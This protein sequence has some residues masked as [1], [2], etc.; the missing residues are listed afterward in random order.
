LI[1]DILRA[2]KSVPGFLEAARIRLIEGSPTLRARQKQHLQT[3]DIL[4]KDNLY[5]LEPLPLFLVAN[6]FFDAL[7]IRQFC[8]HAEGWSE[9]MIGIVK[10]KLVFGHGPTTQY[11]ALKPQWD[12][13]K[14]GDI[15]ETCPSGAAIARDI[16]HG[17]TQNGGLALIIDYGGTYGRNDT[18]QALRNHA[19][20]DP[21]ENPGQAD[22]TAHVDFAGL[23]AASQPAVAYVMEQGKWL[24]RLGISARARALAPLLAET[25]LENHWAATKRLTD[26]SEMGSLFKVLALTAPKAPLAPGFA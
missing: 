5:D 23:A 20:T 7:P 1:D 3:Y 21:L 8:R 15:V 13:T 26:H 16:G 2:T 14:E 22:L 6:E 10:N 19:Y 18:F 11:T 12:K 9:T 17:I 24:N 25:A 4:W